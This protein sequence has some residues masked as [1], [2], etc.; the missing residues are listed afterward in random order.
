MRSEL[1]QRAGSP[2]IATTI[3]TRTS[4]EPVA[5]RWRAYP[6]RTPAP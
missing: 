4:I 2:T 6:A 1:H 3:I 5:T